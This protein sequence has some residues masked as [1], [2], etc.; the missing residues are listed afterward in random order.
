M[1]ERMAGK[2]PA[3]SNA[4]DNGPDQGQLLAAA[5]GW[6]MEGTQREPAVLIEVRGGA[7]WSVCGGFRC[8]DAPVNVV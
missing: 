5:G 2:S 7:I 8:A 6:R 3:A 1:T 4:A